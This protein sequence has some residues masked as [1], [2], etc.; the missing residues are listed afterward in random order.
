LTTAHHDK[1]VFTVHRS[2]RAVRVV[3][4]SALDLDAVEGLRSVLR[5]LIEGQGNL[6]V[7]VELREVAVVDLRLLGV[8]IDANDALHA[9]GRRFSVTT[10]AG[11]WAPRQLA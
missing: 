7:E 2:E 5:D 6:T 10:K 8:L 9:R 4:D 11:S 1:V 3:Y